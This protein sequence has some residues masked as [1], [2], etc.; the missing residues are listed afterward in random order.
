MINDDIRKRPEL[1]GWLFQCL[2]CASTKDV[3]YYGGEGDFCKECKPI[4]N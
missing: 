1:K 3:T 4:K 2:E